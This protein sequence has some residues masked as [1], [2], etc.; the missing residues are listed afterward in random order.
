MMMRRR[1]ATM[2]AA[3]TQGD[4]LSSR[5]AAEKHEWCR[6]MGGCAL[7]AC[8][9]E[10]VQVDAVFRRRL[11]RILWG[12]RKKQGLMAIL[13]KCRA[14]ER[15]F[16]EELIGMFKQGFRLDMP[17]SVL[18]LPGQDF[19]LAPLEDWS[20]LCT[21]TQSQDQ[22]ESPGEAFE[23]RSQDHQDCREEPIL[24]IHQENQEPFKPE[25]WASFSPSSRELLWMAGGDGGDEDLEYY[26]LWQVSDVMDHSCP[27][28]VAETASFLCGE[29]TQG[30]ARTLKQPG[31]RTQEPQPDTGTRATCPVGV[32][33][34]GPQER[35]KQPGT[36]ARELR[37]GPLWGSGVCHAPSSPAM[38]CPRTGGAERGGQNLLPFGQHGEH[39]DPILV[40][41][42]S[43]YTGNGDDGS[44]EVQI[45]G[46]C[47]RFVLIP[48]RESGGELC[49]A[50]SCESM[51][52]SGASLQPWVP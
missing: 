44:V 28:P 9:F 24:S 30:P 31:R 47:P 21:T 48:S 8:T 10:R 35:K 37:T 17:S 26:D 16:H 33:T 15:A 20:K 3:I 1:L 49:D 51:A 34:L 43:G 50:G 13:A 27:V 23:Q 12:S 14:R 36:E 46:P 25:G 32:G 7:P 41:P 39:Y 6:A 40:F 19:G 5:A 52:Q 22:V 29:G 38:V 11:Q 18:W 2:Q 4:R 45:S 42:E